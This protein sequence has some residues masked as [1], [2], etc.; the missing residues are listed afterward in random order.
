MKVIYHLLLAIVGGNT[1]CTLAAAA[2][3]TYNDEGAFRAAAG[4]A[5]TYGFETHGV[6]EGIELTSPLSAAQLDNNFNLAYRNLNSFQIVDDATATGVADGTHYLFTHSVGSA[7]S[8]SLVFSNFGGSNASITAFG[9][10]VTDF[11][12]NLGANDAVS[13]TY[14]TGSLAGTLLSSIGGQ[15]E[16]TQNFVGL[17]VDTAEAFTSIEITLDDMDSGFQDFDEIIYGRVASVPEPGSFWLLGLGAFLFAWRNRKPKTV[18]NTP[19]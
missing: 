5:V 3:I 4:T 6:T 12:S 7:S 13:I 15:P 2:P 19:M 14:D 8:Y 17:T 16:F 10:T 11:A 18:V 1:L 9:F